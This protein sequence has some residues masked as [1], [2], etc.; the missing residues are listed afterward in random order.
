MPQRLIIIINWWSDHLGN[1]IAAVFLAIITYFAEIKGTIVVMFAAFCLDLLLGIIASRKVDKEKFKMSKFFTAIE[2]IMIA[3]LLIMLLFSMG[4]E[5][6]IAVDLYNFAA[7][8]V[9]G[10]ILYSAAENGYRMTGGK[11]FLM[12]KNLIRKKVEEN[13]GIDIDNEK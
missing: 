11:F 3:C 8:M 5:M 13:T 9:T 6:R 2:R 12:I 10:F 7:W 1:F 4:K